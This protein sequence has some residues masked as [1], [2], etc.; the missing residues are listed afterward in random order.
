[1][2]QCT[3]TGREAAIERTFEPWEKRGIVVC[4]DYSRHSS[5]MLTGGC[6]CRAPREMLKV[7]MHITRS[8]TVRWRNN[9]GAC[10][11]VLAFATVLLHS[12]GAALIPPI[13]D[14]VQLAARSPLEVLSIDVMRKIVDHMPPPDHV[15][16]SFGIATVPYAVLRKRAQ[17]VVTHVPQKG[18]GG[19]KLSC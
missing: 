10:R 11:R 12:D 14:T 19:Q 4:I 15:P 2:L 9:V 7:T 16:S 13:L 1:M 5:A 8:L 18:K 6:T 17:R 3:T